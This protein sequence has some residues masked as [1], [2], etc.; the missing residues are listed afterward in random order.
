MGTGNGL[1]RFPGAAREWRRFP[2]HSAPRRGLIPWPRCRALDQRG[3]C[4]S[5]LLVDEELA[6]AVRSESTAAEMYWW[7]WVST[8]SGAGAGR[9]GHGFWP[10]APPEMNTF[11]SNFHFSVDPG[12]AVGLMGLTR[13]LFVLPRFGV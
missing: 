12:W 7:G 1:D 13:S 4:G 8:R 11:S 10:A 3:G 9:G 2:L 5:G 6:R